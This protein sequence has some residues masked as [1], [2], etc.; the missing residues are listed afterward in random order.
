MVQTKTKRK[1][2]KPKN[3][4]R[5][6]IWG[7]TTIES[8]ITLLNAIASTK[9]NNFNTKHET[10]SSIVQITLAEKKYLDG[11]VKAT[12]LYTN[13]EKNELFLSNFLT[14]NPPGENFSRPTQDA[15]TTLLTQVANTLPSPR[16]PSAPNIRLEAKAEEEDLKMHY[17]AKQER[18][19]RAAEQREQREQRAAEQREQRAAEQ[20]RQAAEQREQ[21]RQAAE[22]IEREQREREQKRQTAERQRIAAEKKKKE[23]EAIRQ[24]AQEEAEAEQRARELKVKESKESKESKAE[25]QRIAAEAEKASATVKRLNAEIEQRR[26]LEAEAEQ[27]RQE[28]ERLAKAAAEAEQKRLAAE[29][30]RQAAE[31]KR[32]AAAKLAKLK[33][34]EEAAAA[35]RV[36]EEQK[37]K[38]A[39]AAA[40]EAEAKKQDNVS[41]KTL[42]DAA[43]VS[44]TDMVYAIEEAARLE[45]ERELAE[46]ASAASNELERKRLEA[47][48]AARLAAE[49]KKKEE[50][51]EQKRKEAAA[52]EQDNVSAKTLLD[53]AK[54]SVTD[55]VYAIEL[56]RL[57]EEKAAVRSAAET[58]ER[59]LEKKKLE[60]ATA[61]AAAKEAEAAE[62][63]RLAAAAELE[64]TKDN[65]SAMALLESA[66]SNV[67]N[68]VIAIEEAN[69]LAVE[70][71]KPPPPPFSQ[72]S[73]SDLELDYTVDSSSSEEEEEQSNNQLIR[74]RFPPTLDDEGELKYSRMPPLNPID[75]SKTAITKLYVLTE[76]NELKIIDPKN[77]DQFQMSILY[78]DKTRAIIPDYMVNDL[79]VEINAEE[80]LK[81]LNLYCKIYN[82][83]IYNKNNNEIQ[84]MEG[85]GNEQLLAHFVNLLKQDAPLINYTF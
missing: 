28:E 62:Q 76:S 49:N 34:E 73:S 59:E 30:K 21:K 33:E 52:K 37:R 57:E 13:K 77:I 70:H 22:L 35:A 25:R 38:E 29:Q 45:R 63:V 67:T 79:D 68:M 42:L 16:P 71:D 3:K 31:Q 40:A 85:L 5:K 55:M 27:K 32:Q 64:R 60:T 14:R 4:T 61:A 12:S 26:R 48:T 74:L 6:L 83:Y 2:R 39:E 82:D 23:D 10:D 80:L 17:A 24:K 7:G 19:Q 54:G 18:E 50:E 20:K 15:Y 44:V 75:P 1:N 78:D 41:A 36:A 66:K 72:S 8:A 84:Y 9:I 47:E 65:E 56:K 46:E 69:D 81:L 58:T 11:L 51:A 43:K 53:T